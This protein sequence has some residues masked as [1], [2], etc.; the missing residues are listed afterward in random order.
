MPFPEVKT[1]H[2]A[3]N[4]SW[5]A[6]VF[7]EEWSTHTKAASEPQLYNYITIVISLSLYLF[8]YVYIKVFDCTGTWHQG[9]VLALLFAASGHLDWSYT[10]EKHHKKRHHKVFEKLNCLLLPPWPHHGVGTEK[11]FI[12]SKGPRAT[13][14][15][16]IPTT[17]VHLSICTQQGEREGRGWCG[18]FDCDFFLTMEKENIS[19]LKKKN[20]KKAGGGG[21]QA[22][23]T[24]LS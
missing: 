17:H 8:I 13:D 22:L 4:S 14:S 21:P 12:F 10:R 9:K 24:R 15:K 20:L 16:M 2:R 18:S 19:M 3:V 7:A 11:P 5:I 6:S 23:E 1:L